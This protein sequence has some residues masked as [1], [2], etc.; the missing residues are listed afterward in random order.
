MEHFKRPE[1]G[2]Y[3]EFYQGY[4]SMVPEGDLIDMLNEQ[5]LVLHNMIKGIPKIW[6]T[7]LMTKG[8]GALHRC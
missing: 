7:M 1:E 2:E 4:I 6:P 3:G 8:N 5:Q